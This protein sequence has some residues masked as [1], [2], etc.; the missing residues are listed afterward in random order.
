MSNFKDVISDILY[1]SKLT[2]TKNKK[3]LIF[4]SIVLSQ[5]TAGSDLL[6]IAIFA[7]V[8]ADQLTNIESFNS[9]LYFVVEYKVT[10]VFLVLGRY[11]INYFQYSILKKIELDVLMSLRNYMFRKVLEQK[12]FSTSD[13]YFY[14]NTLTGHISYFYSSFAEALNF[15]LQSIAY[16]IYLLIADNQIITYF[17]IGVIILGYPIY[18]LIKAS[19]N[20]MHKTFVYGKDASNEMVN[21]VENLS[22][23]KILRM[24]KYQAD[25]FKKVMEKSYS[26]IFRNYQ[27][28]FLNN[29]LPNLFTLIIISLIL[30]IS[31]LV[32]RLTLDFLGVT[33]RLF[34]SF[35][36][37][38]DSLNKV[39]NSQVH[40]SEFIKIEKS[41]K[42]L[43][44]NYFKIV[45]SSNIKLENVNFRYLN[46]EDYI[47]ENLNLEIKKNT[48]NIIVGP[49]GS[50]KSTLL[51]L[52]GNVLR[53]ESGTLKTFSDKNA[54]IGATPFIF[55]TT[56][57]ENILYGNKNQISDEVV[58]EYLK[59]YQVFNEEAS[60]ELERIVDNTSLS[61]GQMQKIAFIRALLSKPD[62]LILDESIANLD[63]FSKRL[64][65]N[66]ISK[67]KITVV[68]STHDP[69]KYENIDS[70]IRLEIIDEQRVIDQ[71]Y[72]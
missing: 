55:A 62:I 25:R 44:N 57:R 3:L 36:K 30:N 34:Q 53:P 1:V 33:I 41:T 28:T 71:E 40:I 66:E 29:Q 45:N 10:I 37:I 65:L 58:L 46:S 14:I 16:I 24:E 11:L 42:L 49:N 8:I 39:A 56:L 50:G 60:Y 61:S 63:E 20:Y 23:I 21:A 64:V 5:L 54:Y 31:S 19:R 48:H 35:S 26:V 6:L 38:A 2:G 72:K 68:N 22:L 43:N 12:N 52:I 17:G 51:G 69:E 70:V 32:G 18:L 4:L 59:K 9:F 13:S 27:V 67:Q 47:F 7:A 15:F